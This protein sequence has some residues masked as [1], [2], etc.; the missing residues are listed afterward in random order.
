MVTL[1][2]SNLV[3]TAVITAVLAATL[4]GNA[5]VSAHARWK[6]ST[7]G[8]AAALTV[9]PTRVEIEFSTEIQKVSG[10][11]DI[12]V[13]KDRGPDAT[14]G[15]AV[16]DDSDRHKLSVP[17]QPNLAAGR[18]VV[19]WSNTSDDDGDPATGAFSFYLNYT[20]NA[21]DLANDKQL[22][23]IGFEEET[24][25]TADTTPGAATSPTPAT[26]TAAPRSPIAT[27]ATIAAVQTPASTSTSDDGLSTSAIVA[28][29]AIASLVGILIGFGVWRVSNRGR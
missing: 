6:A 7:P 29:I 13:V 27:T 1:R 8:K 5:P 22:E 2:R 11:Y 26:T 20:P 21:V 19:N 15:A 23:Q 24:T 9:A 16:V 25:P 14:A 10:S 3:V 12:E 28:I 18:Y 4:I 17:L